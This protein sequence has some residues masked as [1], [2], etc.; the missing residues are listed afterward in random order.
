M[1]S[2]TS[3]CSVS[4]VPLLKPSCC[5]A[6]EAPTSLGEVGVSAFVLEN[7]NKEKI[8]NIGADK[9]CAFYYR[10]TLS[11]DV[12]SVDLHSSFQQSIHM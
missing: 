12:C 8:K 9:R 7:N 10:N 2:R 1:D 11:Q 4:N 6:P 3:N 5:L